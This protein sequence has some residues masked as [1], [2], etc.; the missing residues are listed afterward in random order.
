LSKAPADVD[1]MK[2]GVVAMRKEVMRPQISLQTIL[3]NRKPK[4]KAKMKEIGP[5]KRQISKREKFRRKK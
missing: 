4:K 3:P 5:K 1:P 2:A